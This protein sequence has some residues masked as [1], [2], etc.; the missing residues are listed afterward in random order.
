MPN[1]PVVC[2]PGPVEGP[3]REVEEPALSL[4]KGPASA[5]PKPPQTIASP[6]NRVPEPALSEVERV[7]ILR[8]GFAECLLTLT[9]LLTACASPGPPRPPSLHLVHIPTDLT[10]QRVGPSVLLHWT[11]PSRTTDGTAIPSPLT[12][13][14]CREPNPATDSTK[15]PSDKACPIVLRLAVTPGPSTAADPL[16]APLTSDP[17]APIAYRIR[18]V[19]PEH[20]SAGLSKPAL[21]AAGA[22][23]PPVAGLHSIATRNGILLEWQPL[24]APSLVELDRTLSSPSKPQP[25]KSSSPLA[26]SA[27]P[28]EIHLRTG[29]E[30]PRPTDPGGTLDRTALRSQT[31][32]YRATRLRTVTLDGRLYE[33]R[34]EPSSPITVNLSDTFPPLTP[35]GL[36]AIPSNTGAAPTI[37]LSWQPTTDPDLAGYHV[38]RRTESGTFQRLTQHPT[39]GP[40]FSDTAVTPGIPYT[41]RVTAVDNTRNES[42]PSA[43]VTET[44][45][46]IQNP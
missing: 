21:A 32:T 23:P 18:I 5:L 37:D 26:P 42:A 2:H 35:T 12:A 28:T 20:R 33:L 24:A 22:A 15:Q 6:N 16:P 46:P 3:Q 44:A 31:Y 13:E 10:A 25:E 29:D 27:E 36:A 11:T 14:I 30:A 7:S 45:R 8:H 19:N 1:S 43:E 40:A 34:S 9:L 38:Y 39:L 17:A 41:Y 4:P